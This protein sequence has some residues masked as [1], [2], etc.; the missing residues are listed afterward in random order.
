VLGSGFTSN[1]NTV[2]IGFA[3]V[4]N[5]S[6]PDGKTITFQAPAPAGTSFIHGIRIYDASVAN[7]N[8]Q[9][10]SISFWYR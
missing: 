6:S 7:A 10:N 3:A 5:L 2:Q 8:G 4:T 1:G 9:S